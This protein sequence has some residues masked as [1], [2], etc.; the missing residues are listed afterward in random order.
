M[1]LAND[2]VFPLATQREEGQGRR[3]TWM[4]RGDKKE[5]EKMGEWKEEERQKK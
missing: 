4:G 3:R 1:V 2:L 5:E